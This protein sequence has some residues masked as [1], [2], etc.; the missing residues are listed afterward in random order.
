MSKYDL[1]WRYIAEQSAHPIRLTFAEI[2]RIA[3]VELD[4]SFLS[5]KREL[6]AYGWKVGKISMK[7]QTVLFAKQSDAAAEE[8]GRKIP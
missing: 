8:E 3:G 7:D 4:H 5:C 1:L 6:L 2:G